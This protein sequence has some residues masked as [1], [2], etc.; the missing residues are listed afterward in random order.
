MMMMMM[1]NNEMSRLFVKIF[2]VQGKYL[3]ITNF[4][5][6]LYTLELEVFLVHSISHYVLI[7]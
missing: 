1:M 5:Y 6:K 2:P 4:S 7:L 3:I